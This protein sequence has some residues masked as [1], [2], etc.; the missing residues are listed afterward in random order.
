MNKVRIIFQTVTI[1]KRIF[2]HL[3]IWDFTGNIISK[4][5]EHNHLPD[6]AH[7]DSRIV[8]HKMKKKAQKSKEPTGVV[9]ASELKNVSKVVA[10]ELPNR[11]AMARMLQRQHKLHDNFLENPSSFDDIKISAEYQQTY[12][13]NQFLYESEATKNNHFF[14]FTTAANLSALARSDVWFADGTFYTVPSIF[15]QIYTIHGLINGDVVPLVYVLTT[16]KT[17]KTY[18]AIF[19]EL[20]RLRPDIKPIIINADF[21]MAF[22]KAVK[23]VYPDAIVKGCL[24]HFCNAVWKKIQSLG[25]QSKYSD[26]SKYAPELKKLMALAF[27]P[28][29][30]VVKAYEK[31]IA[32]KF[33]V[34]HTDELESLLNYFEKTWVGELNRRGER[35]SGRY[36]VKI[37]NHYLSVKM[38]LPRTNNSVEGWHNGF[39][40]R[41][42]ASHLIFWRFIELFRS[43][44]A[45]TDIKLEQ[46]VAGGGGQNP[47]R[48]KY[49]DKNERILKVIN[50]YSNRHLLTYL[51]G[52]AY[53]VIN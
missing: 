32:S 1:K 40:K 5:G 27:V 47:T 15:Y 4:S 30:D 41:A 19:E 2:V 37:W 8:I 49:P 11:S 24:F 31:L 26:D 17:T 22:H 44:Q 33:F 36:N 46:F 43:E 29:E 3:I 23:G 25:L 6:R 35:R 38:S 9:I 13:G 48:K 28:E 39:N 51:R 16:K 50:E 52:I 20:K 12:A 7:I 34:E 14:M 18:V 10:A 21:E 53:N 45:I 42:Q